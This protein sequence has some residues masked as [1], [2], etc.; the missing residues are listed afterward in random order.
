MRI[1]ARLSALPRGGSGGKGS[2]LLRAGCLAHATS[3]LQR[4]PDHPGV[5]R[6][7]YRALRNVPGAAELSHTGSRLSEPFKK[8]LHG[9]FDKDELGEVSGDTPALVVGDDGFDLPL[10]PWSLTFVRVRLVKAVAEQQLLSN[11]MLLLD[12]GINL[13]PVVGE[14]M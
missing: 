10:A 14:M 1:G 11:K 2:I 9:N 4:H 5:A 3:C 12:P 7:A 6:A 13:L 8:Q